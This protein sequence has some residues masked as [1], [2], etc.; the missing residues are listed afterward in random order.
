MRA[1]FTGNHFQPTELAALLPLNE[2]KDLRIM[3][4]QGGV[5]QSWTGLDAKQ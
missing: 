4:L 5:I 1:Y 3:D 2:I